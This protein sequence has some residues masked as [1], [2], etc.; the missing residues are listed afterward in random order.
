M[1]QKHARRDVRESARLAMLA[2][3]AKPKGLGEVKKGALKY[4]VLDRQ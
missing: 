2:E 3:G 4:P 1:L